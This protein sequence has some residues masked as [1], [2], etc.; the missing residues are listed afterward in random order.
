MHA[1]HLQPTPS[2]A[3]AQL[4]AELRI[5]ALQALGD[6]LKD[7]DDPKEKRHAATAI[8]RAPEPAEPAPTH[9]RQPVPSPHEGTQRASQT[10]QPAPPHPPRP[11]LDHDAIQRVL[12]R[13][14]QVFG[15]DENFNDLPGP[16]H[17]APSPP[18]AHL[19]RSAGQ[20]PSG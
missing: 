2:P 20:V 8:L 9:T 18:T 5:A 7:S 11:Q 17:D 10:P 13:T 6:I 16:R 1:N 4:L 3:Y 15:F 12:A 19:A 14:R